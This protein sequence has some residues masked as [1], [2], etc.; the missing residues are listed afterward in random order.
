MHKVSLAFLVLGMISQ[1]VQADDMDERFIQQVYAQGGRTLY[2]QEDF[3]AG[4]RIA[5]E[6]VYTERNLRNHLNC[7]SARSCEQNADYVKMRADMHNMF[8]VTRHAELD[9][10][11]TLFGELPDSE[12]SDADCG[13]KLSFQSFE[14]PDHAKGNVARAMLYMYDHYDLP[15]IG[16]LQMY[17]Q[18]NRLD[19]VDDAE[20]QRN[21]RIKTIQGNSNPFI[22][23]P[24]K[25]DTLKSRS[26]VSLQFPG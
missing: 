23:D 22:D 25:A 18:W 10:R 8:P 26:P 2:C 6:H 5:V 12:N 19:P 4:D 17:Q 14:P 24:K 1:A 11:R 7:S 21:A 16:T 9:R 20:R 15:L 3:Q 13:Y